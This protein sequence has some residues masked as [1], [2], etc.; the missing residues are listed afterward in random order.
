MLK[1]ILAILYSILKYVND[2]T[3]SKSYVTLP[4]RNQVIF[5]MS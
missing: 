2:V 3:F 5:V 4:I 1:G